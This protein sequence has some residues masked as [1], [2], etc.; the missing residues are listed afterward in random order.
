MHAAPD[1]AV[2]RLLEKDMMKT[3]IGLAAALMLAAMALPAAAQ[4]L[5]SL[6]EARNNV[7]TDQDVTTPRRLPRAV[8]RAPEANYG[9]GPYGYYTTHNPEYPGNWSWY[10]ENPGFSR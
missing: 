8:R 1:G 3:T 2:G 4:P 6:P 7:Q 9:Y 5:S 10:P